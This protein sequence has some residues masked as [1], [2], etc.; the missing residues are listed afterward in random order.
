M[1]F[2]R[3]W[4]RYVR[5][6][7]IANLSVV[8]NICAP[9]SGVETFCNI[10]SPFCTLAILWH[11]CTISQRSSQ[12][13]PSVGD[14]KRKRGS[15][16]ERR[17][18]YRKLSHTYVTFEYLMSSWVSCWT[19]IFAVLLQYR[20]SWCVPWWHAAHLKVAM[21]NLYTKFEHLYSLSSRVTSPLGQTDRQTDKRRVMTNAPYGWGMQ[22]CMLELCL[23]DFL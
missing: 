4:L 23:M 17:W 12:E 21:V 7:A 22:M 8:C 15:K 19:C 2:T 20:Y 3:T 11:P 5:V 14:V 6:F 1:I 18:T 16:I 10:S 9:Y 13:N